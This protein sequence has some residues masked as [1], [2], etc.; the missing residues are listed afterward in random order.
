MPARPT[1]RRSAPSRAG[2][3][4]R[5]PHCMRPRYSGTCNGPPSQAPAC[6]P[7]PAALGAQCHRNN[8]DREFWRKALAEVPQLDIVLDD[9]GHTMKQQIT[10]FEEVRARVLLLRARHFGVMLWLGRG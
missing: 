6:P 4:A 1:R 9:G 3:L 7:H 2:P 8:Q 5:L 10:T